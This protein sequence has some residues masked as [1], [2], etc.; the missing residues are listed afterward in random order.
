MSRDIPSYS[1]SQHGQQD[2]HRLTDDDFSK[3][4]KS[5]PEGL[6]TQ[7]IVDAFSSSGDKLTEA[8]FRKYVQLGLLPRSVRIGRKGRH[9][10]SQGLY[11][12]TVI[13]QI[14]IVRGLMSQGITIEEIQR[15]YPFLAG[16]IDDLSHRI[17]RLFFSVEQSTT[18]SELGSGNDQVVV[19]AL[20]EA[21]KTAEELLETLR[22]IERRLLIR[23]RMARAAV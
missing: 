23:A 14:D 12:A 22:S 19:R 2:V 4:E 1:R 13:R 17:K 11:P 5:N 18:R 15:D 8:T 9:R 3:I 10:G 20:S 6:T 7:Q 16:E 21:R